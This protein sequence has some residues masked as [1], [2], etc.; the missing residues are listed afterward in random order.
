MAVT[1]VLILSGEGTDPDPDCSDTA[2]AATSAR[3]S[4]KKRARVHDK[5]NSSDAKPDS[6]AARRCTRL[7][8]RGRLHDGRDYDFTL[9]PLPAAVSRGC[10][11]ERAALVGAK[12][13]D[14]AWVKAVL[15]DS[16]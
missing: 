5:S 6:K 16:K 4:P 7:R 8:V 3:A 11:K 15:P 2:T 14:G 13:K 12:T 1:E 10:Q 9:P